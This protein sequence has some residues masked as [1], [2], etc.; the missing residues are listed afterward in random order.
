[1]KAKRQSL[2]GW[3]RYPSVPCEVVRPEKRSALSSLCSE[4]TSRIARGA[5]RSYGDAAVSA[6]GLTVLT[7]RLNRMLAFDDTT[8]VLRAEAGVTF[9]DILKVFVPRGWFLPVTPGT[10]Y[11]TLGGA[12][13]F[14]VHGKNH[15]CDGSFGQFISS[16]DLLTANGESVKCSRSEHS[17]LFFATLGGAGLTG[18]ITEV[19]LVLRPIETAYICETR[20]R[21]GNLDET[22]HLF[23]VHE[24]A[25][26]YSVAW[27]DCLAPGKELGRSVLL[28]GRHAER[29]D[30]DTES[31]LQPLFPRQ[32]SVRNV[33]FDIPA[34]ALN[35][36]SMRLFNSL[37]YYSHGD[38]E[39]V[40]PYDTYFYPLDAIQNWNRIYGRRGFVQFQC[41]VPPDESRETLI[42][43]LTRSSDAR[44]GSFLAVLK[45]FGESSG[46]MLS[47]PM[48]GYTLAMDLPV[49]AGLASFLDDL[50]EIVSNAAGRVYLAKDSHLDAATFRTM[51]RE[52]PRWLAIKERVDPDH[53]FSSSLSQRLGITPKIA[54]VAA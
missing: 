54:P 1:M 37:Y 20:Y 8:G 14:D 16:F 48:P 6:H 17:D 32:R 10:R 15:H 18:F 21:A 43:L 27:I 49:R 13:A 41:V 44:R 50:T 40:L 39:H 36:L 25:Y 35:S 5:G 24:A 28:L 51:Y 7:E 4:T 52:Y 33:P 2:S 47:F 53:R 11:V 22:L 45:R 42:A 23:D 9:A 12:V 31:N 3:G 34:F 38:K 46:G 26:P 29:G 19:T 30:L